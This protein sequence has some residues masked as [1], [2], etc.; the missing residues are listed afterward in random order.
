[1]KSGALA[2]L[3]TAVALPAAADQCYRV[4][5]AASSVSFQV[6]QAGSPFHGGFRD[7]GG[8]VC[9]AGGKVARIDVWLAPAS[10]DTGL[11]ELD[12]ALKGDD[13]FAVAHYPRITFASDAIEEHGGSELAR[14]KLAIKD[15]RHSEQ[16]PFTLRASEKPVVS[17]KFSLDRL[18]YDIGT[19]EWANTQWLGAKIMVRFRATLAP[20]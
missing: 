5:P 6:D 8:T 3:L 19:G 20:E 15:K 9:L 14:G 12:Q 11:P 1:M 10:V 7:F 4:E 17:G 16:V 2:L 13:F 18:A